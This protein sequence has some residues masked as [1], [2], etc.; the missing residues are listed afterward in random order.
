VI[1]LTWLVFVVMLFVLWYATT[2]E[3]VL[4]RRVDSQ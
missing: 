2:L 1:G 4:L 3:V